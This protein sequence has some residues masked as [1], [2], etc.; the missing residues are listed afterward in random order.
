MAVPDFSA[1]GVGLSDDT[2]CDQGVMT[3]L[4]GAFQ[5]ERDKR[6]TRGSAD[7]LHHSSK[8]SSHHN[9]RHE[10]AVAMVKHRR[11]CFVRQAFEPAEPLATRDI[12]AE[13][14]CASSST[15]QPSLEQSRRSRSQTAEAS[16]L[17]SSLP[18]QRYRVLRPVGSGAFS[19]VH[20][21]ETNDGRHVAVKRLCMAHAEN[22][23]DKKEQLQEATL[24][25]RARHPCVVSLVD[26]FRDTKGHAH[27][28][29]E[30][31]PETLHKRIGGKPMGVSDTRCY[32]FQLLRA[33]AH[34]DGCK[35]CHRDVKPENILI[36]DRAL[37]LADFGSAK[38]LREGSH[39][40]SYIC[41][42]W[43]RA[44]ELVLGA[45]TYST[46]VDWWSAGCVVAE[47][48]TGRP[49]FPGKS[50]WGS[51]K[52]SWNQMYEI[53]RTL[54]TPTRTDVVAM[55]PDASERIVQTDIGES[56]DGE[57]RLLSHLENLV[58]L[59]RPCQ[60]WCD[61]LLDYVEVVGALELVGRL[62]VYNPAARWPPGEALL[63]QFLAALL[64]DPSPLPPGIFDFSR[65]EL[66]AAGPK[67][68]R[69]L[70]ALAGRGK[71]QRRIQAS[72]DSRRRRAVA[73]PALQDG[74]RRRRRQSNEQ[75]DASSDREAAKHIE[76]KRRRCA[77]PPVTPQPPPPSA[78]SL[79]ATSPFAASSL[80][81][82]PTSSTA[83][84]V[85]DVNSSDGEGPEKDARA[86][87]VQRRRT[88][89]C[90]EPEQEEEL[91][92]CVGCGKSAEQQDVFTSS[93]SV[94]SF[95]ANSLH[96]ETT[97][98]ALQLRHVGESE[99]QALE[100]DL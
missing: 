87:V 68:R 72:S 81:A 9:L 76:E 100:D 89:A 53:V 42:R 97:E 98:V 90:E 63:G 74:R 93:V 66:S 31:V 99:E 71:R 43:W 78:A 52:S 65:A 73:M 83:E 30:Y 40:S 82:S 32:S 7:I 45:S 56:S 48:M 21:A 51:G 18:Q 60:A 2:S 23:R 33:L 41:S 75:S 77:P 39:S 20:L 64:D 26:A 36:L 47:M 80:P 15:P 84:R 8:C 10:D 46:S 35:I 91:H 13:E 96:T 11:Q 62:L 85:A 44:P 27:I 38:E 19:T 25:A 24:L 5:E 86:R 50:A 69:G 12:A 4:V 28:V 88:S 94:Q 54:G 3:H 17:L 49:A 95:A 14:S 92:D 37:R 29:M 57:H 34:L 58:K 1:A 79:V 59:Q 70:L 55:L 22:G 67:A 6:G 16:L 61:L